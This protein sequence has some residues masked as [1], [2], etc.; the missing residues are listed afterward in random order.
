MQK[1]KRLAQEITILENAAASAKRFLDVASEHVQRAQLAINQSKDNARK[2][3]ASA[4]NAQRHADEAMQK[5][6]QAMQKLAATRP[7]SGADASDPRVKEAAETT[8]S[9]VEEQA[10]KCK[11]AAD[12][13]QRN[14]N[15]AKVAAEKAIA[16]AEKA[17]LAGKRFKDACA[18]VDDAVN[19]ASQLASNPH[20]NPNPP[21]N[22]N[23]KYA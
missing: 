4:Q 12:K 23:A 2:A 13:S 21:P 20:L 7:I 9:N 18:K 3:K 19:K 11:L 6:Q 17:K 1:V 16:A 10:T 5:A 14:A 8:A 22:S 15:A